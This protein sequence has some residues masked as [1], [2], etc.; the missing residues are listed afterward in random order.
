LSARDFEVEIEGTDEG[1]K[2]LIANNFESLLGK[3]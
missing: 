2:I 1:Y 3:D